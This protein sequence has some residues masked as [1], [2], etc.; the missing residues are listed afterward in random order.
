MNGSAQLVIIIKDRNPCK[1]VNP[2]FMFFLTYDFF[3]I[4]LIQAFFNMNRYI[5][6]IFNTQFLVQIVKN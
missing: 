4:F 1:Y 6:L 5:N 2:M 3:F